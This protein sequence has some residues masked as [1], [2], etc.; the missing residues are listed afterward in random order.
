MRLSK[1][2]AHIHRQ[3]LEL[4][5]TA[6]LTLVTL[7]VPQYYWGFHN[8]ACISSFLIP[9]HHS[10]CN[11]GESAGRAATCQANPG[12]TDP[13]PKQGTEPTDGGPYQGPG[14]N[15]RLSLDSS[16]LL[17]HLFFPFSPLL[18]GLQ[19]ALFREAGSGWVG[20]SQQWCAVPTAAGAQVDNK[21]VSSPSRKKIIS[22][23]KAVNKTL[24]KKKNLRQNNRAH[25]HICFLRKAA[26]INA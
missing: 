17:L 9:W 6:S 19:L 5:H 11:P 26:P 21:Q 14:S 25:L 4:S 23:T 8:R 22:K 7:Q 12:H 18:P 10:F 24:K 13:E 3:Q 15:L 2:C 16:E 1:Y 20:G